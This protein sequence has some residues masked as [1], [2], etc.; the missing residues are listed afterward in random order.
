MRC[1]RAVTLAAAAVVVVACSKKT[2]PQAA[3]SQAPASSAAPTASGEA[4]IASAAPPPSPAS[5]IAAT[6]ADR[7]LREARSRPHIQPNADDILAAFAEAGGGVVAKRQ[8]LGATYKASFCEGGTTS[9][10]SVT[11]S[12]CEYADA[13]AANA[14]LAALQAIYPAKQARHVM[15]KDTVLTTLRLQD[16]PGAQALE[17]K[18]VTAYMA[19]VPTTSRGPGPAR[20]ICF[21]RSGCRCRRCRTR[22][23]WSRRWSTP[24]PSM[25]KGALPRRWT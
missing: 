20:I 5:G 6:L 8:G 11:I 4:A 22:P 3:P 10:G 15:H 16:G 17:S 14:G 23:P 1:L 7:L 21:P 25:T 12:D 13:P 9:D 18:L 19:M 24:G 2:D